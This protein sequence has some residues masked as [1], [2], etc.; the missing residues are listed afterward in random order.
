MHKAVSTSY[1][2]TV[3]VW[4][5][6]QLINNNYKGSYM[7]VLHVRVAVANLVFFINECDLI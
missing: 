6:S 2:I 4:L 1:S 3:Y 7:L 5:T